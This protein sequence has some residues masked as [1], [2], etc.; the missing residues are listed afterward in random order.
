MPPE[1]PPWEMSDDTRAALGGQ[2]DA[3]MYAGVPEGAAV[4][5]VV[6]Q[7]GRDRLLE[8]MSG[9]TDR[10]SRE[11]KNA[12]DN[13]SRWRRGARHPS[14][15]S[16]DR[17][18]GAAETGRRAE[19][20]GRRHAHVTLNATVRTS[21]KSWGLAKADLTGSALDDFMDAREA[22][23]DELAAQIVFDNYGMDPDVIVGIDSIEGFEITW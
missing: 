3:G 23:N 13:L 10:S 18:R 11:W 7:V 4:E 1:Y 2:M 20:R 21:S 14:G 8:M 17:M 19:I 12:R 9:T 15:S 6:A 22:G 5:D 16:Q